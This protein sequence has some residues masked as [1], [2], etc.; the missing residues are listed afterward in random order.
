LTEGSYWER[1]G[2]RMLT[3]QT[4]L[5]AGVGQKIPGELDLLG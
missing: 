2:P 1:Q 4:L 3:V 5:L